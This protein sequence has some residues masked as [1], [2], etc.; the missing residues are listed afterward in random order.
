MGS[1]L[2]Q[3]KLRTARDVSIETLN[4]APILAESR[5]VA[6]WDIEGW[7]R[8]VMRSTVRAWWCK[9]LSLMLFDLSSEVVNPEGGWG[10][11]DP[12]D[13]AQRLAERA[14]RSMPLVVA[15]RRG[16]ALR[17]AVGKADE[18]HG[19]AYAAARDTNAEARP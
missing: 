1:P 15:E 12:P 5:D 8:C 16:D 6:E 13:W 11:G 4:M 10:G 2:P 19:Q 3:I 18:Y 17:L 14:G 9:P 7:G